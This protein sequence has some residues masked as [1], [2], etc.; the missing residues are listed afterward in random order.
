VVTRQESYS[1]GTQPTN[2]V[3]M[4]HESPSGLPRQKSQCQQQCRQQNQRYKHIPQPTWP[5][6][7]A[8]YLLPFNFFFQIG[9]CLS[10]LSVLETALLE[11]SQA[12]EQLL[13][14]M[15]LW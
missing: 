13:D 2:I 1:S 9:Y 7:A 6:P 12:Q 5:C 14:Q 4:R 8:L 15:I 10:M 11:G 3:V